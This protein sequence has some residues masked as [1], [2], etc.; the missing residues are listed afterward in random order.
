MSDDM[1]G[2]TRMQRIARRFEARRLEA[3]ECCR[4]ASMW[5]YRGNIASEKGNK[6]LAE[7]HYA[8]CQ[9]WQ[10]KMNRLLGN[11]DGSDV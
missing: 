5:L 10:D 6:E 9:K 1:D 4:M 7:R 2:L 11:G 8:R 3:N